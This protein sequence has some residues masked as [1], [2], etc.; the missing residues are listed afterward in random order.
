MAYYQRQ[1]DYKYLEGRFHSSTCAHSPN[2]HE[3]KMKHITMSFYYSMNFNDEL[4]YEIKD[5]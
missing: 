5:R 1:R 3:I 4:E 2:L